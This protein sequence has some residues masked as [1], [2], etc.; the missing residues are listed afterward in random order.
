MLP[1]F[2]DD[3]LALFDN[4]SL[5]AEGDEDR[6]VYGALKTIGERYARNQ[7]NLEFVSWYTPELAIWQK[8]AI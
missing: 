4:T 3:A 8:A 2:T 5:I 6:R 7:I 1:K